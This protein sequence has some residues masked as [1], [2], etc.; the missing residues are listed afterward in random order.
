MKFRAATD[1][2]EATL[3]GGRPLVPGEEIDLTP[4]EQHDPFN[5]RLIAEGQLISISQSDKARAD[6]EKRLAPQPREEG[7]VPPPDIHETG[8]S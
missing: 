5:T 2:R 6:A 7:L 3:A 4:E 8:G 1:A